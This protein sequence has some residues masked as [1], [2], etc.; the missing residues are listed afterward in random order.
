M[1][2]LFRDKPGVTLSDR[3]QAFK[4]YKKGVEKGGKPF[5]PF[6]VWHDI[7][8]AT[9]VVGTILLLSVVWFAQANC[10]SWFDISCDRAATPIEQEFYLPDAP[11]GTVEY[12]SDSKGKFFF[13]VN[14]VKNKEQSDGTVE[15]KVMGDIVEK[16]KGEWSVKEEN[17]ELPSDAAPEHPAVKPM[18][19][20]LYEHKADPATTTYH[21][22]PEWYFYF[23]FYL[24]I[25]FSHPDLV[26]FGTII[27]PN[28][29]LVALLALP[30]IDRR[31]ERRPSRRPLAMSLMVAAAAT[32]LAFTWLGS[33]SGRESTTGPTGLTEEQ[34]AMPGFKLLFE[35]NGWQSC[36][37]CHAIEGM[38]G[39]KVG[40]DLTKEGTVGRGLEWQ[41]KHLADP[42]KVVS[43]S[44]MPAQLKPKGAF[45]EEQ[46]AHLG[47]FLET[48]GAPENASKAEIKDADAATT[49]AA[50]G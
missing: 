11:T 40:P 2:V 50:I 38:G 31:R 15:H 34:K 6:G 30:F 27:I 14:D 22:R 10:D 17:V 37:G 47:A 25:L 43:G 36:Q 24:L 1:S 41:I 9:V 21:P 39:G 29:L 5:F 42:G 16:K 44:S 28:I 13:V 8:A 26:V 49:K 18:L 20:P 4:R 12:K 48:L 32:M 35:E 7:I 23:L 33:Q 3:Q 19:G 45:D 46:I